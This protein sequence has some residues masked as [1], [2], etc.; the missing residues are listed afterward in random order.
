MEFVSVEEARTGSGMRLV[1]SSGYW[2]LWCE[3][4]KNIFPV[5]GV[6]FTAVVHEVFGENPE[7][8]AWTGVRNQPQAI[9][10]DE[11]VRTGR[12]DEHTSELQS[13]MRTSYA[14]FYLEHKKQQYTSLN[15]S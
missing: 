2:A 4:T 14:V 5:K 13:L 9:Y 8:V 7:L 3:F 6:P 1:L 10:N 12:S 11:P 15:S